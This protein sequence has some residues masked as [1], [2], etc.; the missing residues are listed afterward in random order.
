M[1]QERTSGKVVDYGKS[2]GAVLGS[3]SKQKKKLN[4]IM[5]L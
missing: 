5:G 3:L 4:S 1:V 2:F